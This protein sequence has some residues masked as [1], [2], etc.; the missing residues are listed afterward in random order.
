MKSKQKGLSQKASSAKA[1]ISD[2]TARRIE[3]GT[4]RPNRGRPRDWKTRRDPLD[5]LWE[6]EL[7]PR[8]E[9]EPRLE[10]T[11]IFE[12]LQERH[13]GQ[14]DDKLKWFGKNSYSLESGKFP[15]KQCSNQS[16]FELL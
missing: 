16:H 15:L 9:A 12:I 2:R 7:R 14:Y 13:P 11:T 10:A 6:K 1:G 8:R 3:R 4:H 5:G